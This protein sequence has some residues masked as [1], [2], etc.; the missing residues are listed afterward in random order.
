MPVALTL[1][2]LLLYFG[3]PTWGVLLNLLPMSR[4]LQLHRLI[5]GFHLGSIYLIGIGL[6]LPWSWALSGATAAPGWRPSP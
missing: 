4:D 5:S 1:F 6:A 3:R 2:W